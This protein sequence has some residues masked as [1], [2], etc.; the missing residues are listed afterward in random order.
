L[1]KEEKLTRLVHIY[2]SKIS[3]KEN[4]IF[5]NFGFPVEIPILAI[6]LSGIFFR[7]SHWVPKTNKYGA[8]FSDKFGSIYQKLGGG[9]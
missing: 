4:S 9:Y 2:W 5:G 3:T 8:F 6:F 7:S 1:E